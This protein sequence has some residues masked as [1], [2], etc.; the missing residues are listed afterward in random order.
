MVRHYVLT[1]F[2]VKTLV[3]KLKMPDTEWLLRRT[4]MISDI[5]A[6]SLQNQVDQCFKWIILADRDRTPEIIEKRLT[7][8]CD[9]LLFVDSPKDEKIS[10][11]ILSDCSQAITH[12]MTSGLD[13]DDGYHK[14]YIEKI[15]GET[16]LMNVPCIL[17]FSKGLT[18]DVS[19]GQTRAI[20]IGG[21]ATPFLTVIEP[22][23]ERL[24][25]CYR[26][27][28]VQMGRHFK[29]KKIST[30]LPMWIQV[31]HDINI[32]NK[33]YGEPIRVNV[34]DYGVSK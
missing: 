27:H 13:S 15:K 11:Y 25:T 26:Y 19:S 1:R 4:N 20:N 6:R 16:S 32:A 24:N 18:Y 31:I 3:K 22:K 10:E 2:N 30:N 12:V 14:W 17:D 5:P 29:K 34:S 8:L 21:P 33:F 23:S 7:K 9:K 28:H